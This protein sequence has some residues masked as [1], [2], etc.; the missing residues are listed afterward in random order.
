MGLEGLAGNFLRAEAERSGH[1]H[2]ARTLE[3]PGQQLPPLR[4]LEVLDDVHEQ[5]QV[6]PCRAGRLS[7]VIYANGDVSFCETHAPLGNLRQTTFTEI[8]KSAEADKLRGSIDA[9]ACWC[10]NEVV[11][12]PS[13][14]FQPAQLAR[15]MALSQPWKKPETV[16]KPPAP[17]QTNDL[18]N[19][20]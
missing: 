18:I 2:P 20:G 14:V 19:I 16:D 4:L 8:W 3:Q 5:R 15:A 1:E 10:T 17:R 6:V 12:W 7:A 13:I 11:L 9:N